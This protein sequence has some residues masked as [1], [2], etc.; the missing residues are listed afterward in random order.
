MSNPKQNRSP[1]LSRIAD[2]RSGHVFA[3]KCPDRQSMSS[4]RNSVR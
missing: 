2:D 3:G 1:A 4:D